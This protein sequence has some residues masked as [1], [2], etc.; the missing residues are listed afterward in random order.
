M[1]LDGH[2]LHKMTSTMLTYGTDQESPYV[3]YLEV[4]FCKPNIAVLSNRYVKRHG[5]ARLIR[6]EHNGLPTSRLC[7]LHCHVT[8]R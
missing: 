4:V 2:S 3:A 5:S 6:L 8:P 7:C 1:A